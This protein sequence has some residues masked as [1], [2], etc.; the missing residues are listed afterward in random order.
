MKTLIGFVIHTKL[1]LI[2]LGE[3]PDYRHVSREQDEE[4]DRDEVVNCGESRQMNNGGY[5]SDPALYNTTVDL[6]VIQVDDG[7]YLCIPWGP[8]VFN[9]PRQILTY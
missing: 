3:I 5:V 8:E 7:E 1:F 6:G 9:S 4:Q 2:V